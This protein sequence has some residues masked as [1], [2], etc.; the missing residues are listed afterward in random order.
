MKKQRREEIKKKEM[1]V[2]QRRKEDGEGKCIQR[3]KNRNGTYK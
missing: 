3:K 2:I 1:D